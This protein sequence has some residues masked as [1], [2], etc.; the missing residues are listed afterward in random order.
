MNQLLKIIESIDSYLLIIDHDLNIVCANQTMQNKFF[1]VDKVNNNQSILKLLQK[2][3]QKFLQRK[4]LEHIKLKENSEQIDI[5]IKDNTGKLQNVS[6]TIKTLGEE[7][8]A[9]LLLNIS[10]NYQLDAKYTKN[11]Q[12]EYKY[13]KAIFDNTNDAIFLAP[14]SQEGVH[15]NFVKVNKESCLRLGYSEEELLQLNARTI[16]PEANLE[17]IRSFGFTLKKEGRAIFEA[18]H[19]TKDGNHIPV[20]VNASVISIDNQKFVLSVV[21]D[22]RNYKKLQNSETLFG[23]LMNHSWNEIYVFNSIDLQLIMANKG[24]L[25]N[26]GFSEKEVN[27]IKFIDLLVNSS[28]KEFKQFTKNLFTGDQSQLV[29]EAFFKRKDGSEY[30]VEIRLQL[31]HSEVPPVYFANVQDIS[32][33]KKSQERLYSLANF[34]LLTGLPNRALFMDRLSMAIKSVRRSDT[35]I[36]LLFIDL[37][38][39]KNI[40][41]SY[42][43]EAGDEL[44]VEIGLR[45]KNVVRE[46]DTIARLGGDEFTVILTNL[47]SIEPI[48][49]IVKKIISTINKPVTLKNLACQ[50]SPS[51]GITICPFN[52]TN[53][54]FELIRQADMAMYQAKASGKNTYKFFNA[55]LSKEEAK[56]INLTNALKNALPNNEMELFFQPRVNLKTDNMVSAEVLLR[57]NSEIYGSIPPSTFIPLLEK[58][59]LIHE[60][61]YWIIEKSC[62]Q[63]SQWQSRNISL[64]LSINVSARQF[65]DNDFIQNLQSFLKKYSIKKGSLEIEI[66]EG[67]LISKYAGIAEKLQL[68]KES[69]VGISLDDFGTGYSSLSYLK[70]YPI[71]TLKIDQSFIL[72]MDNNSDSLAIVKAII[73][74]AKSLNQTVVAEGIEELHHLNLLKELQCDEGQGYY[75]GKPMPLLDFNVLLK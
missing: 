66:T 18:I 12:H 33:R 9:L 26:L 31:S 16:N 35:L 64:G 34:D 61:G 2:K 65:E 28:E 23:R 62:Q 51:I 7:F 40:N 67:L 3:D 59:G 60:I 15:G 49:N 36:A 73:S 32:E 25:D 41:D 69:G 37:D 71:D 56:S 22:Q 58:S 74:L 4:I 42:G 27:N 1:S 8:P 54:S 20:E 13:L 50:V 68:L 44:L 21:K 57:W 55:K 5:V 24:A 29:Y 45:L 52:E 39:F 38:G 47:M 11:E 6:L 14:I 30:P 63:L 46:T 17:K 75:L 10:I 72:D 53:D 48:E 19:E 43:H 70:Q